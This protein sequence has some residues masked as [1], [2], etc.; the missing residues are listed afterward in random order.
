MVEPVS[1]GLSPRRAERGDRQ[2]P[3]WVTVRS[4][5]VMTSKVRGLVL[6]YE[7]I[8]ALCENLGMLLSSP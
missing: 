2:C 6:K 3:S 1:K 8:I 7:L 5:S 4:K